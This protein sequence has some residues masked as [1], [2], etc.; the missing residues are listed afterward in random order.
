[1]WLEV[2]LCQR[3]FIAVLKY[4]FHCYDPHPIPSI[5]NDPDTKTKKKED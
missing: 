4:N 2:N 1:M 3:K 5:I